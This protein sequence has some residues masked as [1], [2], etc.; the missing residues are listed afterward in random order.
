[1]TSKAAL[2]IVPALIAGFA[3]AA[4]AQNSVTVYGSVGTQFVYASGTTTLKKLDGN[5]IVSPRLGFKGQEDLGDGLRALFQ[6]E[7]GLS[8]DTGSTSTP[9]WGRGSWVGLA[10]SFGKLSLGRQW[11]LNDDYLCGLYVCGGYAAFYNFAGFGNS[12]DLVNNAVKYVIPTAGGFNAGLMMS[13]GEGTGGRYTGA[14][15]T[16]DAGPVNVGLGYDEQKNA[17]GASD[18]LLL[19]G[20]K[21]NFAWGFVRAAYADAKPDASGVGRARAYDLGVGYS[22]TPLAS[23]SLDYVA[24][25]RKNSANDANF[26][27]LIGV[28]N[29]SKRTSLNGNIIRLN[30]KGLSSAALAGAT[31]APGDSQRVVTVGIAHNF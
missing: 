6:L 2:L 25:D 17:A 4:A 31:V 19:L 12:S 10:G 29:L 18:K 13:P 9:F 7:A 14:A 28:Y 22:I 26:L 3:G 5:S 30:N 8:P 21:F 24:L 15:A 1:M 20:A 16:Y 23:V 11:N 27:R